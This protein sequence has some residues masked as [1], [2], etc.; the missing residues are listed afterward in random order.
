SRFQSP[1][2]DKQIL[3]SVSW[4]RGK[5]AYK[6]GAEFRTGVNDE[7]RDR[8]SSGNLT[9]S[10]LI[11]SN[12]G[13]ANT[14]NALASFMLGEVNSAS[15]QASDLIQTRASYLALYA[16]DDWRIKSRLTINY[17]LRW[18][19]E[20]PRHELNNKQNSFDLTKINPVSGTPGVVTFA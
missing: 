9:F 8:G 15:V 14:G 4:S 20:S 12:L 7:T 13:A 6:F 5:H 1:V 19:V 10:P 11:T 17:G 2:T 3:E 16:Q 18:E